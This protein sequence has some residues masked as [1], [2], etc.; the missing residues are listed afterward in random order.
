MHAYQLIIVLI[1]QQLQEKLSIRG[2]LHTDKYLNLKIIYLFK[3]LSVEY[4]AH[5]QI[6]IFYI[7]H[8]TNV[9]GVPEI[10]HITHV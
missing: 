5:K 2:L 10:K 6:L 8:F 4:Q 3:R 1:I 9:Q 7:I